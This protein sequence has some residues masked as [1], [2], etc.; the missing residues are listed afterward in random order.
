MISIDFHTICNQWCH[1]WLGKYK[2]TSIEHMGASS[3]TLIHSHPF[4][5]TLIHSHPLLFVLIHSHPLLSILIHSHP[6]L[7]TLIHSHPLLSILIHSYSFSTTLIHSHTLSSSYNLIKLHIHL[8]QWFLWPYLCSHL[9]PPAWQPWSRFVCQLGCS[10]ELCSTL[11]LH[12]HT[13][14]V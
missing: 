10:H 3:P 8:C 11:S 12:F 5:S 1:S 14:Q 9:L 6:F 7:S 4:L 2:N 13:L